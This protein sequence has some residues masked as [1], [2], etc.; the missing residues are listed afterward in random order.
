MTCRAGVTVSLFAGRSR[1]E[2]GL[3]SR[4]KPAASLAP[5][6]RPV[7]AA[8]PFLSFPPNPHQMASLEDDDD[9]AAARNIFFEFAEHPEMLHVSARLLIVGQKNKHL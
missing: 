4:P 3:V 7:A 5:G 8:C 1:K 2:S 9:Y 6:P